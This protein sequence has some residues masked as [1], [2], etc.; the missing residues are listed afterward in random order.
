MN[1]V[2][3]LNLLTTENIMTDEILRKIYDATPPDEELEDIADFFKVFGDN[4]RL[5]IM[6]ALLQSELCVQ[7]IA[8]ALQMTQSAISHQLKLLKQLDLVKTRRAGKTIFYSLADDH[9]SSILS[10]G[11][12]H[13]EE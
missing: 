7:D 8:D 6:I 5:K 9:I 1:G 10:M 3:L 11:I 2:I 4:T 12:D 13:I